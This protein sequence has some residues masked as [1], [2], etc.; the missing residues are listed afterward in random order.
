MST[1]LDSRSRYRVLVVDDDPSVLDSTAAVLST[2]VEVATASSAETA[3][4]LLAAEPFDV[5]C[6]DFKMSGM[7]GAELLARVAE[8]PRPVGCLLITGNDGYFG[9]ET[10]ARHH[11]LLK[12]FDPE[13][14]LQLVV[15]LGRIARQRRSIGP[16]TPAG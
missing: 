8:L 9:A 11:V 15:Q 14:L 6:A 3:L 1:A 13:R 10:G 7:N 12:P 5:V 2:E 16:P 4:R